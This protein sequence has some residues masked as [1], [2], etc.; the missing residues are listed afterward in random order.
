MQHENIKHCY[1]VHVKVVQRLNPEFSSQGNMIF[2]FF[3]SISVWGGGYSLNL[4]WSSFHDV[5]ESEH[6]AAILIL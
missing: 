1:I 4:L 2:F 5:W 6:G 3:Y